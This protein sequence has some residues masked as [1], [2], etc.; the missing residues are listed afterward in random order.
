[1]K[2]I[3]YLLFTIVFAVI[4]CFNFII[5][6]KVFYDVTI[7]FLDPEGNNLKVGQLVKTNYFGRENIEII[8]HRY[9]NKDGSIIA[10]LLYPKIIEATTKLDNGLVCSVSFNVTRQM[11]VSNKN[12]II[13]LKYK[14]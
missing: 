12:L 1:M 2:K 7:I 9:V 10:P 3:I 8:E 13:H 11:L 4:A 6:E 14:P 5:I